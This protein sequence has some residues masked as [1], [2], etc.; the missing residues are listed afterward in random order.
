[1]ANIEIL[2]L[3]EQALIKLNSVW[4]SLHHLMEANPVT[5]GLIGVL[6]SAVLDVRGR[7]VNFYKSNISNKFSINL[8]ILSNWFN[9]NSI[10][11]R[12]GGVL[13]S[14]TTGAGVSL[15]VPPS[16]LSEEQ[17]KICERF[18]R[19][20]DSNVG[21]AEDLTVSYTEAVRGFNGTL[22]AHFVAVQYCEI[23]QR[24][25]ET[26]EGYALNHGLG[27]EIN[28]L[29]RLLAP[30]GETDKTSLKGKKAKE[31]LSSQI[32]LCEDRILHILL[33]VKL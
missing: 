1:M 2:V 22:K 24:I 6:L 5:V 28:D 31:R 7:I 8:N 27:K 32:A 17:K 29:K 10:N 15:A 18:K 4:I 9:N 11:N 26:L 16:P 25:S 21:R 14:S 19:F 33:K 3:V 30:L 13:P 20:T 12:T 23:F